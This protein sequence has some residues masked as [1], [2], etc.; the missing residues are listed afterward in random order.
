MDIAAFIL[1]IISMIVTAMIATYELLQ[2]RKINDITL[3]A[4][5]FDF[6]F[7]E[8]MLRQIP[9][10]RAKLVFDGNGKLTGTDELIDV[11]NSIRKD[12]IYFQYTD[13]NFYEKLKKQLQSIED[14]LD[15][16]ADKIVVAEDQTKFFNELKKHIE[17][18]YDLMLKKHLGKKIK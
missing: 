2:N 11:L 3:E 12:S 6:L 1:S 15:K 16:T 7:K 14:L 4:E 8:S 5:Y 17:I 18:L 10:S 13:S 9:L